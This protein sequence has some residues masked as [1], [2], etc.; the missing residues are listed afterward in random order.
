MTLKASRQISGGGAT[1]G[2]AVELD[3]DPSRL[4][5]GDMMGNFSLD[6][7]CLASARP[8]LALVRRF[9]LVEHFALKDV[10]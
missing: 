10:Q 7:D 2:L 8:P 1:F 9:E 4:G 5:E 6:H 3:V